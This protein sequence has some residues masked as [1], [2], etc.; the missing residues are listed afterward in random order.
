MNRNLFLLLTCLIVIISCEKEDFSYSYL[1]VDKLLVSV[2]RTEADS[3]LRAEFNYDSLNRIIEVK[4]IFPEGEPVIESYK[5]SDAGNLVEKKSGNYTT[6]YTYN[7][8]GQ[9]IE[10]NAQYISPHDASEWKI[11][12]KYKDGKIN[13]GIE[14][15]REGEVLNYFS[16][17]YDSKGNTLEKIV[18][19]AGGEYDMNLTETKFRYDT[20]INPNAKN[21]VGMLHGYS[22]TQSPDIKQ[23]NNPIYSFYYHSAMSSFPPE[24]EISYE[25]DSDGLPI[26]AE[27]K[28]VRFPEQEPVIVAYVYKDKL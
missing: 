19:S 26:K 11:E 21:G 15:S 20:N 24:Y 22:F 17:K 13:K 10:Q 3:E 6:T 18:R 1:E 23:I 4:N 2:S 7:S 9:L 16:Y 12:F 28:N 25:Y 5:Y 14:Y 27:M 8:A